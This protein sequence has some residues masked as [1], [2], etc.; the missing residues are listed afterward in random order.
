VRNRAV[1]RWWD[2]LAFSALSAYSLY[3]L[4]VFARSWFANPE[5]IGHP[6]ILLVV[7]ALLLIVIV[8][9]LGRWFLLPFMS[10]PE[11]VPAKPGRKVAMV[12]TFVPGAEPLEMLEATV[13]A[14]A[15]CDYPH[16]TWVL[17]EG[18]DPQVRQLCARLGA[19][20]FTRKH[21]IN[22]QTSGGRFQSAS[23]HGNYNSWLHETGFAR[24]EFISVFDPDHVPHRVFLSRVLGYFEDPG[25]AFVQVAQAYYNQKASFIARGAAEETYGYYSSIQMAS[26]SFGFPVVTGSHNTH[27]ASALKEIGGFPAHDAEDLLVSYVYRARG[28]RGVYVPEVLARG[29]T[30]VDWRGYLTQQR[31]WARS[32]L[33]VK[34]KRFAG[35]ARQI[36]L[37]SRIMGLLH[38]LNYL[39]KSLVI[40]AA[41][42]LLAV[43][44]LG[45]IQVSFFPG[46]SDAGRLALLYVAL[47]AGELYRQ[48]FYLDWRNERGSHWRILVLQYA[49]WP[50]L[51][52]A[53]WDVL[54]GRTPPYQ[55]TAKT[56]GGPRK[57]MLMPAN[58]LV[59]LTLALTGIAGLII[60][61]AFNPVAHV[62][63]AALILG[64]ALLIWS[65]SLEFPAPFDP[66]LLLKDNLED[67]KISKNLEADF[68]N[69]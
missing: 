47:Q 9:C 31:R 62:A 67:S 25:I 22:H 7:T 63:A 35:Y 19:H 32:V 44:L 60:R 52:M 66:A 1:F 33:D 4:L 23:K 68:E 8:A 65:E 15:A 6:V 55:L 53:L 46:P 61:P 42:L 59:I 30:P 2:Y 24:Y 26:Y 40:L 14:M 36:S 54:S 27:R 3:T 28:W 20:H 12:T 41:L 10:R 29:I 21:S 11:P 5:W 51:L 64:S 39:H 37:P 50:F 38:G 45:N 18:D 56:K 58:A 13:G 57:S 16:D 49:K 69:L 48:R 17:D 43:M 34:L